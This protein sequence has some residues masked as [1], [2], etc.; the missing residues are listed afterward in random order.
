[1]LIRI[2]RGRLKG[3]IINGFCY[4]GLSFYQFTGIAVE[5]SD[6][7]TIGGRW[8]Y[9]YL[10]FKFFGQAGWGDEYG[11]VTLTPEAQKVLAVP[12][13]IELAEGATLEL[14]A[15]YVM[16]VRPGALKDGKFDVEVDMKKL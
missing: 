10:S 9:D 13:N 3:S 16:T 7:E 15:T 5:E 1:M 14:G 12:G 4:L 6:G 8:R 11:T 2:N